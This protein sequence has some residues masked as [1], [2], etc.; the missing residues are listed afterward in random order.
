[1]SPGGRPLLRVP[2]VESLQ[3]QRGVRIGIAVHMDS[4]L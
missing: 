1:M 2:D 4:S 3:I